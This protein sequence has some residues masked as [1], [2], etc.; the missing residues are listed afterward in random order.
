M[1]YTLPLLTT[2]L[3][4][5]LAALHAGEPKPA[6]KPN[7]IVILAD[8]LGYG[9]VGCYGSTK[10]R[11]PRMDRL[12]A[13][14]VRFT[15][16]HSTAAVCN[17][18]RYAIL[19]GTYLC[20]AQRRADYSLYFHDGQITLPS[21]LQSAG[22]CTAALGKWHNGFGRNGDPDYNAELKPGP[23]EIGFDSFF[24]TPRT[25]NEPPWVFV[26]N[27]RVVGWDPADPIRIISHDEVLRRGLK[28]YGWGISE[29]AAHAHAARPDEQIDLILAEKAADFLS[30]TPNAT[31]FF[32]YLAFAAPHSPVNP[33]PEFRG[34]SQAGIY[35]DY[36]EQLDH[37]L[38]RVLDAL[39]ACGA[40]RD[41]LVIVT[42][43][44]GAVCTRAAIQAGH[45]SNGVLLGQ[46]T[47]AW[48]GGHRVPLIARWP[49]RIPAGSQ[50]KALFTQ[51][52]IMATLAEAAGIE[53]PPGAS[54]D[55]TSD[56]AAFTDPERAPANRTE[57]LLQG[58]GGYALRQGDWLYIPRQGSGGMT[59]QVPPRA[60][61]GLP[62][63]KMNQ[64][65]SD[66]D[67]QGKV[68]PGAPPAQLYNLRDD[69]SQTTNRFRDQP[70]TAKRL[71]A[72][73]E[74][75][76]PKPKRPGRR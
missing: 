63:A 20:H 67:P 19:A 45:R 17:P 49:G 12:A 43:D 48:E 44:N 51:V 62:Y 69:L 22:Y 28:D 50:R 5:P 61:W 6:S 26:E 52:D 64:R 16:A 34:R 39:D 14:G 68:Q 31:P 74:E 9:D 8:D 58:T 7:I 73:M 30:R 75:L 21:L 25:H 46:K 42:S 37:C 57:A 4:A 70:A 24:G 18:S 1:K 3:L 15:D 11:T 13:D 27:H 23:L 53:L 10:I 55:G 38:G 59:V 33:A 41:T 72:R 71:A 40:A 2:L 32:L 66:I 35:G 36:V 65:N 60:P 54:P 76:L 56:L 29:G 47:D